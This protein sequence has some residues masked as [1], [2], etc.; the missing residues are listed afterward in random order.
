MG[1]RDIRALQVM[2]AIIK[3]LAALLVLG[4]LGA[5]VVLVEKLKEETAV[6]QLREE[7]PESL[8]NIPLVKPG[9]IAF[10]RARELPVS[11]THLTLPTKA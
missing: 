5:T 1:S 4:V 6:P 10:E 2:M 8:E 11:Y 3:V 9:E 7:T